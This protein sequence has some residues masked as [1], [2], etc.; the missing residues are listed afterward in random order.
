[1]SNEDADMDYATEPSITFKTIGRNEGAL[2][3]SFTLRHGNHLHSTEHGLENPDAHEW[4]V[5][6]HKGMFASN[7]DSARDRA[8]KSRS[9]RPV[10]RWNLIF[11]SEIKACWPQAP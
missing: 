10:A 1:M 11:A 4:D 7:T 6:F 2:H 8:G 5:C 3:F 9:T